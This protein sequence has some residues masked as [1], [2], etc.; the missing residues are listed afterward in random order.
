M[1]IVARSEADAAKRKGNA[2]ADKERA[3][4]K[5]IRVVMGSNGANVNDTTALRGMSRVDLV[6]SLN[7]LSGF[8]KNH[9]DAVSNFLYV[10]HFSH[11]SRF[12][13]HLS[14]LMTILDL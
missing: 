14:I 8:I 11:L 5:R 13:S 10:L 4:S 7:S 12:I 1:S 6:G 2:P 9:A 3:P